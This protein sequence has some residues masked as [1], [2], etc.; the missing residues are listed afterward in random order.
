MSKFN[1]WNLQPDVAP[2]GHGGFLA[3][4]GSLP[5]AF[6]E[7]ETPDEAIENFWGAVEMIG[8]LARAPDWP[9]DRTPWVDAWESIAG[10][11]VPGDDWKD[12]D[13]WEDEEDEEADEEA[14]R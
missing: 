12:D 9:H 5:G 8:D 3:S 2:D 13:D 7:G 6:G 14:G 10:D 4:S 11:E 1:R